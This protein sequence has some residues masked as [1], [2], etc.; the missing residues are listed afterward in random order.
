MTIKWKILAVLLCIDIFDWQIIFYSFLPNPAFGFFISTHLTT[1]SRNNDKNKIHTK[2][3]CFQTHLAIC[4]VRPNT[5][6]TFE[7]L[8]QCKCPGNNF[9]L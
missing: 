2:L 5:K 7:L 8:A 1:V 4:N 6:L 9:F 3:F